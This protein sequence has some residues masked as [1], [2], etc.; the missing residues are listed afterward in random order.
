[1]Y[2]FDVD[3]INALVANM[4]VVLRDFFFFKI[5]NPKARGPKDVSYSVKGCET[6]TPSRRC[7]QKFNILSGRI[8]SS[9]AKIL[10]LVIPPT[11]ARIEN[12]PAKTIFESS[13]TKDHFFNRHPP[14]IPQSWAVDRKSP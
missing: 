1:M 13:T 14:S 6:I 9:V 3:G 12:M 10:L 2:N 7:D 5:Q 4:R 11:L 8:E